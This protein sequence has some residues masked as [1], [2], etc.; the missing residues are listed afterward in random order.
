MLS[1]ALTNDA[2]ACECTAS[3]VALCALTL[4]SIT[5]VVLGVIAVHH[6]IR[7]YDKAMNFAALAA[8]AP[9]TVVFDQ[10]LIT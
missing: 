6:W 8:F 2:L 5:A 3:G 1:I 4:H 10:W 7:L 9:R